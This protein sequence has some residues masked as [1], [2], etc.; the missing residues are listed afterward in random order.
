MAVRRIACARSSPEDLRRRCAELCSASAMLPAAV[1]CYAPPLPCCPRLCLRKGT[2]WVAM[3]PPCS[4]LRCYAC[5]QYRTGLLC[6]CAAPP[7]AAV[8]CRRA[9][10]LCRAYQR[11]RHAGCAE[12]CLRCAK[13]VESKQRPRLSSPTERCPSCPM[14]DRSRGHL[15]RCEAMLSFAKAWFSRAGAVLCRPPVRSPAAP[16]A[17]PRRS[18]VRTGR[19]RRRPRGDRPSARCTA[20]T[21]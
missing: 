12:L 6:R 16:A 15:R 4:A 10:M 20:S 11:L 3:P 17:A 13:R 18:R 2:A 21:S 5:A 8:L 14:H 7:I 1:R 9:S 19:S